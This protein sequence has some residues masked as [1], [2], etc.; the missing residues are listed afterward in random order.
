[1]LQREQ[2]DVFEL[3]EG[4]LRRRSCNDFMDSN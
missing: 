1:M 2:D 4:E 3:V